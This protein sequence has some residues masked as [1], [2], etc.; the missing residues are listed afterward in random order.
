MTRI[1]QNHPIKQIQSSHLM[2]SLR[3]KPSIGWTILST[4][5]IITNR[6]ST[7][8]LNKHHKPMK[9]HQLFPKRLFMRTDRTSACTQYKTLLPPALRLIP[10]PPPNTKANSNK[11][12]SLW[13]STTKTKARRHDISETNDWTLW[14]HRQKNNTKCMNPIVRTMKKKSLSSFWMS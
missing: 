11:I 9:Y 8:I 2:Q 14:I 3:K 4:W 10:K 5:A 7:K 1:Y 13:S 12:S 6:I